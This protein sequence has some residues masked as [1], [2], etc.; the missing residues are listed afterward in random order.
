MCIRDRTKRTGRIHGNLKHWSSSILIT[1]I[2]GCP[3]EDPKGLLAKA[4]LSYRLG[5]NEPRLPDEKGYITVDSISKM[6]EG[7]HFVLVDPFGSRLSGDRASMVGSG[8]AD[9][10][11]DVSPQADDEFYRI[12][13]GFDTIYFPEASGRKI[14]RIAKRKDAVKHVVTLEAFA[15]ETISGIEGKWKIPAGVGGMFDN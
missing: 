14:Y 11:L 1:T 13:D 2:L 4:L 3:P 7:L 6:S 12:N 15:G 8:N 5:E 10:Q 9:V